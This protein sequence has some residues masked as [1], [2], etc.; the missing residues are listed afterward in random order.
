MPMWILIAAA[1]AALAVFLYIEDKWITTTEYTYR[2]KKI[3]ECFNGLRILQVSDLQSAYFGREQKQLLKKAAE[4][5]PDVIFFTGDLVDRNRTNLKAS[6]TAIKR[7]QDLKQVYYVTGNHEL[8]L[9]EQLESFYREMKDYGIVI[10]EDEKTELVKANEHMVI[11][12]ISDE[13]LC[14][15]KLGERRSD[16]AINPEPLLNILKALE[17]EIREDDF[18]IL[19]A[20]EPQ[21]FQQ[22]SESSADL[23]FTGH[24][25]GGQIRLPFTDGLFAPGQGIL[26]KLASGMRTKENTTMVISRGL[27]NSVFPFRIFNR[28]ELV[29]VVLEKE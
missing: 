7:L 14:S 17:E 8:A 12:G 18:V 29:S 3:P 6:M 24:A 22:Y 5:D 11:A 13:T 21:F 19:L 1:V 27:G 9:G 20:H 16:T 10:L 4:A 28:P 26:P 15:C 2:N 23:V 25:H